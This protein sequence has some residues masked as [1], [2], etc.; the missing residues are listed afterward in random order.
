MH[1]SD[2]WTELLNFKP[3]KLHLPPLLP[4]VLSVFCGFISS[5]SYTGALAHEMSF[6]LFLCHMGKKSNSDYFSFYWEAES[7]NLSFPVSMRTIIASQTFQVMHSVF[8]P[9]LINRMASPDV[10]AVEKPDALQQHGSLQRAL[11]SN[12][13]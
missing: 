7:C 11:R 6:F 3:I 2:D 1:K 8:A 5:R 9:H 12:R 13:L 10:L 4:A